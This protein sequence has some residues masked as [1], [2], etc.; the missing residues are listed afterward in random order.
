MKKQKKN[1]FAFLLLFTLVMSS[2]LSVLASNVQNDASYNLLKGGTQ[3]FYIVDGDGRKC[4]IT[5][6]E[7]YTKARISNGT[8]KVTYENPGLW[9]AG[10]YVKI[11]NNKITS[12]YSSFYSTVSGS[13]SGEKLLLNS[14][15]KATFKFLYKVGLLSY[16]T[17][18]CASISGTSLT[19]SKL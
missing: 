11:S 15:V 14:S 7:L 1:L 9:T 17:G 19:V 3:T 8:Y 10:F 13:I 16:N 5:V 18:I 4:V 6:E 12:A 2:T